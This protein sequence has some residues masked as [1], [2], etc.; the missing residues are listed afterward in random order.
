M[1]HAID[2]EADAELV[3]FRRFWDLSDLKSGEFPRLLQF[4]H[5]EGLLPELLQGCASEEAPRETPHRCFDLKFAEA[6]AALEG[7]STPLP[8]SGQRGQQVAYGWNR[9]RSWF[10]LAAWRFAPHS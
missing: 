7:Q 6:L 2:D 5:S 4:A 8:L 9:L 10:R 3:A 1:T